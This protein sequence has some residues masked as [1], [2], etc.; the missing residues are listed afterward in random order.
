MTVRACGFAIGSGALLIL[1]FVML[2]CDSEQSSAAQPSAT[3]AMNASSVSMTATEEDDV[4]RQIARNW[5][6]DFNH[7]CKQRLEVRIALARDGTVQRA[8]GLE[9]FAS[10][11]VCAAAQD[12]ALRAVWLS[13]PLKL[14]PGRTWPSV[15]L[16]FD[17]HLSM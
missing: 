4:R 7:P 17:Q 12:A 15:V 14:P 10:D 16:L 6:I 11:Q 1:G 9:N 8:E 2:G 13:S 5:N 3:P